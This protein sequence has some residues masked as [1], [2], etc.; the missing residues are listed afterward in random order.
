MRSQMD[1]ETKSK[2]I[3]TAR[4]LFTRK[5]Y[6]NTSIRDISREAG[7]SIGAIYH[8]FD[9][10]EDIAEYLY[11]DTIQ[12]L[13]RNL[14]EALGDEKD[15]KEKF[16]RIIEVFYRL[17]DEFPDIMEYALYVKH[18]EI[19]RDNRT[20]CSSDPFDYIME[21]V[22]D[23][24][25][26]GKIREMDPL[27]AT[28]T[29]MGLPIRLITLKLDGVIRDSLLNYVDETLDSCWRALRG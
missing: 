19:L 14:K 11:N 25:V 29:L 22:S 17:T 27:L 1:T 3:K 16:R 26:T 7:L 8:Y 5:G 15:V 18:R 24:I 23:A 4:R 9:G 20:I 21:I 2:I 10:K 28:A 6:F 12:F 13:M